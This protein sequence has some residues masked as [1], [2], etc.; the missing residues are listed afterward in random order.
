MKKR[1]WELDALRGLCLLAIILFHFVYDLV[2]LY[3]LADLRNPGVFDF[4]GD[5]LGVLFFVIS[6]ICATLGSRP[7]RR[8]IVVFLGGI[9][10]TAATV[11]LYWLGFA[12]PEI[13]IYFGV[14]HCIGVCMLLWPVFRKCPTGLLFLL[15]CVMI[16]AGLY[17]A[18]NVRVDYPWLL[19]LGIPCWGLVTADYFP[20]LPNL[21]YFC[22]GGGMGRL[23]YKNKESLLPH[24]HPNHPLV[25]FLCFMGRHSL[26]VYLLHQP[27]LAG[28][29]GLYTIL[30]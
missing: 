5:W 17:L 16:G 11:C 8:G 30:F 22:V 6:G 7:V 3:D 10:V 21:G 12:G 18:E 13:L 20:L 1:I 15:G 28:V 25:G 4:F 9:A 26:T 14:L 19:P 23:L 29:L 24:V 2:F 27:L